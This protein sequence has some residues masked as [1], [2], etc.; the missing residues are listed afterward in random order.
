MNHG[1]IRAVNAP[2][3]NV[4]APISKARGSLTFLI[5][6]EITKGKNTRGTIAHPIALRGMYICLFVNIKIS[7]IG[8]K[9]HPANIT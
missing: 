2:I 1:E 8:A 3:E 4:T 7:N 6:E 5:K 9:K